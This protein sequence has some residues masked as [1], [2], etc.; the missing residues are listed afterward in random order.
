MIKSISREYLKAEHRLTNP[1]IVYSL[2]EL[3]YCWRE[4]EIHN[5]VELLENGKRVMFFT[6]GKEY[7]DKRK[8][9]E[10]N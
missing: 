5:N 6:N 4:Q 9:N 3:N 1:E 7:F 2:F 10:I 8:P